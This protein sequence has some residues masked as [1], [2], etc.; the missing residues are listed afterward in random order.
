MRLL[1]ILSQRPGRSGSGVFLAAMVREAARRGYEQHVIV[2]GPPETGAAE[3]PP[4]FDEQISPIIFPSADAPFPV[5]GNSDVMPYP[6]SMF[7]RMSELQIEQY[8]M[9]SRR[10]ME[11]VRAKFQPELVHAHH[12]WLMCALA[13]EVFAR[14]PMLA[15]SHNAE[16]R[17]MIKA[18]HLAPGVLQDVRAIEKICVLTPQ[19]LTDTVECF[20]VDPDRIVITGA[21][22]RDDLFHVSQTPRAAIIT[23]L[24]E[25]FGVALPDDEDMRLVTFVGRL[26]TPKGIPFLLD[27]AA[28]LEQEAQPFRILLVG[29][30][31]SGEDG[32]KMDDLVA[33]AHPLAIHLGAQPQ[34]AVAKLLQVSTVFVLPSLFEGLPLTMLEALACGCPAIV[35]ALPTVRSWIPEQWR[36][37]GYVELVPAL[38]TTHADE[39]VAADVPRFVADIAA[40][41]KRQLMRKQTMLSRSALAAKLLPHSWPNVFNRYERV[42][43][44]LVGGELTTGRQS[45]GI[46]ETF[47]RGDA[48]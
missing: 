22:F 28:Q 32:R 31:G 10:V 46:P 47:L 33:A 19:S 13:R 25:R 48:Q 24:R 34:E 38:A 40:A 7:S 44:K 41:L 12:L 43:R 2:A 3:L 4:L 35:S 42:Y 6:T 5:P 37:A 16:L 15:T 26:S 21:G 14:L 23:E 36:E 29:A 27:A 18:P 8:L 11:D 45:P 17:Q 30:T 39:P 9:V 1:H 20:G